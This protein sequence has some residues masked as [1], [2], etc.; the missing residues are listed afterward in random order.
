MQRVAIFRKNGVQALVEFDSTVSA[1]RA[2]QHL[3]GADIYAGC[4][5]LKI[6]Y[7]RVCIYVYFW[8]IFD[9]LT[10]SVSVSKG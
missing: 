1:Q 4:C 9:L 5:T 8:Y 6:E 7:A 10:F 3:D 2:K